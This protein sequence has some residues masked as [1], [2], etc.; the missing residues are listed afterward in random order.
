[1]SGTVL[2]KRRHRSWCFRGC[3]FFHVVKSHVAGVSQFI[4]EIIFIPHCTTTI[5]ALRLIFWCPKQITRYGKREIRTHR[6]EST[7]K[8]KFLFVSAQFFRRS[9]CATLRQF[10]SS[11]L[12]LQFLL[13]QKASSIHLNRQSTFD[14][15]N[16]LQN[17]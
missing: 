10:L 9:I 2:R 5:K 3:L 1:M 16:P 7:A 8:S 17:G 15:F 6:L 4:T 11:N 14:R 13:D 12:T